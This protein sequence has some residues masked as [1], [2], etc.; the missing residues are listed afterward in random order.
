MKKSYILNFKIYLHP[1]DWHF[2]LFT[3]DLG[4]YGFQF[5]FFAIT[6]Y[7]WNPPAMPL[8][9][10]LNDYIVEEPVKSYCCDKN[11]I[12]GIK[13]KCKDCGSFN[14]EAANKFTCTECGNELNEIGGKYIG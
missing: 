11:V 3:D 6:L 2:E 5:L 4:N 1:R 13:F 12:I 9:P 10:A 8:D 7:I 14:T